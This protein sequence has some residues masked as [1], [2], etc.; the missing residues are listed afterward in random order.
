MD[1]FSYINIYVNAFV[2]GSS[3]RSSLGMLTVL[4]DLPCGFGGEG[5]GTTTRGRG[6]HRT[7]REGGWPPKGAWAG[8]AFPMKCGFPGHR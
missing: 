3:P 6:D 1:A 2:A 4:P 8:F 7:G 5:K